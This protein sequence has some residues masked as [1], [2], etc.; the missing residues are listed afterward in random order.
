MSS[1]PFFSPGW[2]L[3]SALFSSF[4]LLLVDHF[5]SQMLRS[6]SLLQTGERDTPR[7]LC[8]RHEL[9]FLV[10]TL[11]LPTALP[12]CSVCSP[13]MS[14]EDSLA[15]AFLRFTESFSGE[16]HS[17]CRRKN[18]SVNLICALQLLMEL[19]FKRSSS[20]FPSPGSETTKLLRVAPFHSYGAR[21]QGNSSSDPNLIGRSSLSSPPSE[22][23]SPTAYPFLNG[24]SAYL[25]RTSLSTSASDGHSACSGELVSPPVST[26]SLESKRSLPK[27]AWPNAF[28]EA[29]KLITKNLK[30][31]ISNQNMR[32]T[33]M[34]MVSLVILKM[35]EGFFRMYNLRLLQYQ[36]SWKNFFVDSPT[37]VSSS[38]SNK[39]SLSQLCLPSMNGDALSDSLLSPYFNLLTEG[40]IETT[41]VF[42]VG[43]GCS[44]TSLVT[45][46]QLSDF[47]RKV[48]ST[49]SNHVL[50]SL[51][52]SYEDLSCLI[53]CSISVYDW[54]PRGC[55]IPSCLC[56]PLS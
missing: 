37:L 7:S 55:L 42:L 30:P 53:S 33:T 38:S 19:R 39:E 17:G 34:G 46:S 28:V 15:T 41:S 18:Y 32:H 23:P 12:P 40:A 2:P 5:K 10:F 22:L 36:F 6:R 43:E 8:R 16:L 25:R 3:S 52:T 27:W 35:L 13:A 49:H 24:G 51:S 4:I 11:V 47:V 1:G 45:I 31:K 29:T 26:I 20:C 54:F 9:R 14:R 48:S 44:S 56:S 21:L 50:N